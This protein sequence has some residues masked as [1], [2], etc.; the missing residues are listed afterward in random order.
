VGQHPAGEHLL[1]RVDVDRAQHAA[2]RG[3][4][5]RRPAQRDRMVGVGG[6]VGDRGVGAGAGQHSVHGQQQDRLQAVP[7]SSAPT[8]IGHPLQRRQQLDRVGHGQP[9]GGQIGVDEGLPHR[10][11]AR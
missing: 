10:R 9:V 4:V 3:C 7:A 1:Q 5:R 6:P 11:R 2:E 8:R